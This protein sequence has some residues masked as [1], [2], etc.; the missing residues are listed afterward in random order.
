VAIILSLL[1]ALLFGAGDFFGGMATKRIRVVQVLLCAHIIG[2]IGIFAISLAIADQ[3]RIEDLGWGALAGASGIVGLGLLYRGLARG[4]MGVVG[5]L[6]AITSAA[7]P[8]IWGTLVDGDELAALAWMGVLIAL[9]AIGLVSWSSDDSDTPVTTR[10]IVESLIA[11]AG[12]GF[13]FIL[14]DHS[15]PASAP[16]P[17]AG[18]RMLTAPVLLAGFLVRRKRVWPRDP[19]ALRLV[20]GVAVAD[21]ISNAIFLYATQHGSLT[22]V[23]VLS[24]LYPVATV[25]LARTVLHEKLTRLQLGGFIL[26]MGATAMIAAG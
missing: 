13:M 9:V 8:A 21:T 10:I 2:G 22:V 11:G 5:A 7:V 12:F 1:T 25:I 24:S 6:T 3:F 16:W 17:I 19:I 18:A 4:P 15:D 23:A 14:L 20:V 26:A